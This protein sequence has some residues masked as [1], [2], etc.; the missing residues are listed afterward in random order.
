MHDQER[1]VEEVESGSESTPVDEE[2]NYEEIDLDLPDDIILDLAMQAHE[3]NITL[4]KHINNVLS[5]VLED[6]N[7]LESLK[8]LKD[9]SDEG[10][11]E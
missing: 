1:D 7:F 4:N 9:D 6:E 2:Q 10:V 3:Q 5:K 11:N 8:Q